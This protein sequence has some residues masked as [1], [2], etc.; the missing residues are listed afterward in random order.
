LLKGSGTEVKIPEFMGIIIH[1]GRVVIS[2]YSKND[3]RNPVL[4]ILGAVGIKP[5]VHTESW[6]G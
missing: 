2:D 6:C 3:D 5:E 1:E 4:A